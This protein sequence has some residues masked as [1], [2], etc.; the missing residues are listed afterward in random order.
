MKNR[1]AYLLMLVQF[2]L[3]SSCSLSNPSVVTSAESSYVFSTGSLESS[4]NSSS[5]KMRR[6][7]RSIQTLS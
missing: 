3:V 1:S 5:V 6:I 4:Q 7:S 2:M